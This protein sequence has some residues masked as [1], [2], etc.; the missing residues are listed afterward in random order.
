MVY[1][2]ENDNETNFDE[3][4]IVTFYHDAHVKWYN[5]KCIDCHRDEACSR[6]HD[7]LKKVSMVEKEEHA[8][9]IA[10]HE[11]S[12][13][14]KCE[15]C[16]DTKEKEPFSHVS[17]GWPLGKYHDQLQC[18]EC[19]EKGKEFINL[20]TDCLICHKDWKPGIFRHEITGLYLDENH[21]ELECQDCHLEGF[22]DK[23]DCT[24]C[25]DGLSIPV[26][27]TGKN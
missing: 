25:H 17:K 21:E 2:K 19:H 16:H 9:C 13:D 3:G 24:D 23:P 14:D 1:L 22:A 26:T 20:T 12:I 6:C 8:D 15:K 4:P 10:W 18:T 7:T 27:N 11:N 5:F